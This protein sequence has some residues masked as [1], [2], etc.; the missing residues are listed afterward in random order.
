MQFGDDSMTQ[1]NG[2]AN[3]ASRIES[4]I[5]C[6]IE[7]S[8]HQMLGVQHDFGVRKEMLRTMQSNITEQPIESE[9]SLEASYSAKPRKSRLDRSL[10][11]SHKRRDRM[12]RLKPNLVDS[13]LNNDLSKTFDN[14][15][16]QLRQFL[17]LEGS[18]N[19][20]N[21]PLEQ[22]QPSTIHR[23]APIPTKNEIPNTHP[24]Q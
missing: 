23:N 1:N 19:K 8:K 13:S 24:E 5:N 6:L 18:C 10:S 4:Q 15:N 2:K 17:E 21:G 11:K 14:N 12:Q 20:Q 16:E 9:P 3:Q 7:S 22:F